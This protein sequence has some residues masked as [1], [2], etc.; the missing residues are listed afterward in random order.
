M[1]NLAFRVGLRAFGK[2]F[3]ANTPAYEGFFKTVMGEIMHLRPPVVEVEPGTVKRQNT[4]IQTGLDT[5]LERVSGR[6]Y[7]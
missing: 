4:S 6:V 5:L 2:S 3:T 7:V 1:Y